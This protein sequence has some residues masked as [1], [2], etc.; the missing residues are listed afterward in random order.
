M[1]AGPTRAPGAE[2]VSTSSL[3]AL[4]ITAFVVELA[5]F[6][7]VGAIAHQGAGGGL[8]GWLAALLATA[9]VL[10]LWG[11]LVAPKARFRLGATARVVVSAALCVGTAYGLVQ[12]DRP[13]WGWFVVLAGLAVV[14][15]QLVLPTHHDRAPP[16]PGR[17]TVT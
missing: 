3:L 13:W 4:A 6:G 17:R 15:A 11:L 16:T 2:R 5:L 14:A 10:L 7:G 9:A 1:N 12:A 8:R